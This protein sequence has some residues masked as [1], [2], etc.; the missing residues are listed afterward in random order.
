MLIL[1][2]KKS[3]SLHKVVGIFIYTYFINI[4]K[5][6]QTGANLPGNELFSHSLSSPM[7][8]L[9]SVFGMGTGVT[10]SLISPDLKENNSFKIE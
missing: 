6:S 3:G 2:S 8:C 7:K 1:M 9:T 5:S 10:T 4:K